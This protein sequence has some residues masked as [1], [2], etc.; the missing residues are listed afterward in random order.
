M[1]KVWC[2]YEKWGTLRLATPYLNVSS[3]TDLGVGD[4]V[5][6]YQRPFVPNLLGN[7]V[8]YA[9][10]ASCSGTNTFLAYDTT[11]LVYTSARFGPTKIVGGGE[12][13]KT[14]T[15]MIWDRPG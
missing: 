13:V 5:V 8:A 11:L 10:A 9:V 14:V 6:T 1:L 2:Q 3:V 7:D 12:D 4:A 15:M